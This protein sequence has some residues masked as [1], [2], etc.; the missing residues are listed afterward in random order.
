[1]APREQ[2]NSEL[3]LLGSWKAG[4][5]RQTIDYSMPVSKQFP[6]HKYPEG[7]IVNHPGDFNLKRTTDK[8]YRD[9]EQL[10]ASKVNDLR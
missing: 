7:E 1:M 10:S 3:R 8:E 4:D 6:S 9:R 2:D 5:W